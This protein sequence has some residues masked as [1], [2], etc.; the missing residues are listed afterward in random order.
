M[1]P[2]VFFK[3]QVRPSIELDIIKSIYHWILLVVVSKAT[4]SLSYQDSESHK[5]SISGTFQ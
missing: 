5:S 1:S 2:L 4:M 3:Q